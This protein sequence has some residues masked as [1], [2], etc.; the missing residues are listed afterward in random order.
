MLI[1]CDNM[2]LSKSNA[3]NLEDAT[4]GH[5]DTDTMDSTNLKEWNTGEMGAW[6]LKEGEWGEGWNTN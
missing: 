3:L 6:G 5:K 4:T 2:N 1:I